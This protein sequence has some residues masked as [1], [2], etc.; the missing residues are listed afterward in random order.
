MGGGIYLCSGIPGP[1]GAEKTIT[2]YLEDYSCFSDTI[3]VPTCDEK[4]PPWEDWRSTALGCI[5]E[6][7]ILFIADTNL[8]WLV[9]DAGFT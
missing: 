3:T 2:F 1:A 5:D 4:G 9:P 7:N 8:E 6:A